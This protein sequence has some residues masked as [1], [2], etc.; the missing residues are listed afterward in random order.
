M[1][2][3]QPDF[4]QANII[5]LQQHKP[6]LLTFA[7]AAQ[8]T[9]HFSIVPSQEGLLNI[10][11][12]HP[13]TGHPEPVHDSAQVS[14]GFSGLLDLLEKEQNA[15][16]FQVG[17]GLG[18]EVKFL[19][20]KFPKFRYVIIEPHQE[21]FTAALQ[22]VDLSPLLANSNVVLRVGSTINIPHLLQQ[23]DDAL[24][25]L[26]MHLVSHQKLLEL[27][28]DIYKPLFSRLQTELANFQGK[29]QTIVRQGPLLFTNT[30]TNAPRL[31][32]SATVHVLKNIAQGLPAVCV[33][34]GPSLTKNIA[35]LKGRENSVFIIAVDSAV[36]VLIDHGIIPHIIV[37]IDPI[38]ASLVKL[39]D[40]LVNHGDIA[41]AWTPE[42]FPE[43]IRGFRNGPKF[44]IPGINDLFR[45]FLAPLF[46]GQDTHFPHMLSVTH[47]ATQLAKVAGCNP[48]IFIG[49]DLALSGEQDH[50]EGSPI[51]W[52][53][54]TQEQ[55]MKIPGWNGREVETI[56]VLRNQLLALQSIISQS[57]EMRFI[58]ATEGGALIAGTE[59]M[60][61]KQ[62]LDHYADKQMAFAMVIDRIFHQETKPEREAIAQRLRDLQKEVKASRNTAQIGLNNGLEARKQWKIAKIP[63]KK[64]QA[65]K[66]FRKAVIASG[67][68]F[69][70][71]MN[72]LDLANALYPLR[73]PAHHEF[74][75]ARK[76]FN[77]AAAEKNAEQSIFDELEQNLGYFNSWITTTK[78]AEA[79]I[80]P[81]IKEMAACGKAGKNAP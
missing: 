48:L 56:A 57:K 51:A 74:I 38:A 15:I 26:P 36:K 12:L 65:I 42:A 81:I 69:D 3:V 18:D 31:N 14:A 72:L 45:L 67:N 71:L 37:T 4:L 7:G 59:I 24:R 39:R 33:A 60:P 53:K 63:S 76:K 13:L 34:S 8:E 6:D 66:K 25:A 29:L 27:F 75:Y 19:V 9:V 35:L 5:L 32:E 20:K 28:P 46:T 54:F 70:K 1:N 41:L 47:A 64:A 52:K 77:E 50:A 43:T 62:A 80:E 2:D 73:A 22:A 68:S 78:E 61:L 79:I 17:M 58:D 49:L 23:E 44:V 40:V 11:A 30:I 16:I 10:S 21:I 55:R